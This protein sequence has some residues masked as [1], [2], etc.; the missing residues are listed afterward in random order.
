MGIKLDFGF[1]SLSNL[2]KIKERRK[3][4]EDLEL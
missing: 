2:G 4:K 3:K 1:S